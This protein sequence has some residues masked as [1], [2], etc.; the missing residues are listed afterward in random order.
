MKAPRGTALAREL[1]GRGGAAPERTGPVTAATRP[2]QG[3]AA[4]Q[5]AI[6]CDVIART[7]EKLR[8][9]AHTGV[10]LHDDPIG[11]LGLVIGDALL[12]DASYEDG[13]ETVRADVIG[14]P[15][16]GVIELATAG[17]LFGRPAQV[18][19]R[20]APFRSAASR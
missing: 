2:R 20:P 14:L 17:V 1:A 9:R 3:R 19:V 12:L 4:P 13:S 6:T 15:T 18:R 16:P 10:T 8:L 7:A 5:T 11:R